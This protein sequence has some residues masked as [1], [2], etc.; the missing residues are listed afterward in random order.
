MNSIDASQSGLKSW[1][2]NYPWLVKRELWEHRAL[3][4]APAILAALI[5][6]LTLIEMIGIGS[7]TVG[8][9]N[10]SEPD[11]TVRGGFRFI[12]YAGLAA[13]FAI[14]AAIVT[15]YYSLDALYADR[16]DR[17]VLFWKSLPVSDLETVLS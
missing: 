14:I 4:L 12:A 17:S 15:F 3:Y 10:L 16:R 13:P 9:M 1:C 8:D 6:L 11:Q 7:V 5:V 2:R